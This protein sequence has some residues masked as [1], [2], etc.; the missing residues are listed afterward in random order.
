M[1]KMYK[2][3]KLLMGVLILG[4][5]AFSSCGSSQN[6]VYFSN[7][8]TAAKFIQ[9]P[10]ADF[11]EPL[12]QTD[13]ILLINVQSLGE[14]AFTAPQ[15]SSSLGT[16]I[17]SASAASGVAGSS[18][19]GFLVNK[20]GNVEVPM[21]GIVKLAGL[22]TSEAIE[23]IRERANKYYKDP[24][25]QVRF[26]NYKITI[27]GEVMKPATYTVPSEK[28]T[29]LDAISMAGDITVYGKR[30]NIM[31][32]RDNGDKKDIVRLD[33]NSS[34]IINSPYFY[35]KQNDVLYIEPTKAKSAANSAPNRSL[36][37]IGVAVATLLVTIL[38]NL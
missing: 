23:V 32:M 12:I 37:T 15:A 6:A 29:I 28:V 31:L 36:I 21:L 26:A 19:S 3:G 30:N 34:S 9:V 13:D 20:S 24:T 35:L 25:V 4:V 8:D 38:I 27:L 33:L 18:I 17:T 1:I 10:K 7:L 22:T 5:F 16:A 14:D 2:S 11:K